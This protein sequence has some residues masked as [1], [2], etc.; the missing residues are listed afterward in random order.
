MTSQL[1]C[2][3]ESFPS[4][5][6]EHVEA[7]VAIGRFVEMLQPPEVSAVIANILKDLGNF[8]NLLF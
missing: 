5:S 6:C 7:K 8:L 3:T 1:T 4:H 2:A